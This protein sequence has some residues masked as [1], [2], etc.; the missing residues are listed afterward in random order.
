MPNLSNE[1]LLDIDSRIS[2]G[3]KSIDDIPNP[4]DRQEY[5]SWKESSRV[6]QQPVQQQPSVT[7]MSAFELMSEG[8]KGVGDAALSMLTAIPAQIAG[9][10]AGIY[11]AATTDA[12]FISKE[13]VDTMQDVSGSLTYQPRTFAGQQIMRGIGMAVEPLEQLA[14]SAGTQ[15]TRVTGSPTLGGGV[16]TLIELGPIGFG[17]KNPI[18]PLR[19]RAAGTVETRRL[20]D[21][22]GIDPRLPIQQQLNQVPEAAVALAGETTQRAEGLLAVQA[23]TQRAKQSQRSMISEFYKQARESGTALVPVN[24]VKILNETMGATLAEGFADA[25][26]PAVRN[27]L[28]NFVRI[29]DPSKP[30]F[31]NVNVSRRGLGS[32]RIE[33][34]MQTAQMP[35]EQFQKGVVE[36]NDIAALRRQASGLSRSSN[37]E[38]SGA[39]TAIK[40]NID[41]WMNGQFDRDM[42]SGVPDAIDKWRNANTAYREYSNIF[43]ENEFMKNIIE[44]E[45]TPEMVADWI[46]GAN[47]VG[48]MSESALVVNRLNKVLGKDSPE[49][50]TVRNS[51]AF[52]IVYP[53]L[54]KNL[55]EKSIT[56]F[57]TNYVDFAK[58][59]PSLSEALF[60][61]KQLESFDTLSKLVRSAQKLD[62]KQGIVP[63]VD[64]ALAIALFPKAQGLAT[65][66]A[67][68]RA[69]ETSVARLRRIGEPSA[70]KKIYSDLTGIDMTQPLVRAKN[71]RMA[72]YIESAI[73]QG[74]YWDDIQLMLTETMDIARQK[75][76][77]RNARNRTRTED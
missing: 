68:L 71:A 73:N 47:A 10:Y 25:N 48:A 37:A 57:Q 36:L 20:L 3:E 13:V 45:A 8:V 77:E 28:D 24:E 19:N 75:I 76:N 2:S 44:N 58:K 40:A 52:D 31:K 23:A 49:M 51:V 42:I 1:V 60:D 15:V 39:A 18:T 53:I 6:D 66:S 67:L 16:Q 11:K 63:N 12:D 32:T 70:K 62:N 64:R 72:S 30:S 74:D 50:Q 55:D 56:S 7:D 69:A 35:R 41:N 33:S 21:N 59:N 17:T 26:I 29:I 22:A 5:L 43:N 27:I 34:R 4:L 9:G 61:P 14:E 65:G 46:H 38:V 54:R